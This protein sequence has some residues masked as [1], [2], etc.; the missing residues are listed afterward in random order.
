MASFFV[1]CL[2]GIVCVGDRLL[3]MLVRDS[4][5]VPASSHVTSPFLNNPAHVVLITHRHEGAYE[6]SQMRS[7]APHSQGERDSLTAAG[8]VCLEQCEP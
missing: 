3:S 2:C 7:L 8:E 5:S 1:G 6:S 4:A